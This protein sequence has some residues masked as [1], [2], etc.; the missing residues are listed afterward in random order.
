MCTVIIEEDVIR[1]RKEEHGIS[2]FLCHGNEL[3]QISMKIIYHDPPA[4][5]RDGALI[6]HIA[7]RVCQIEILV[8]I[9]LHHSK[10][11][12]FSRKKKAQMDLDRLND[13]GQ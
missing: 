13:Q 8:I 1:G 2:Y 5:R 9:L 3:L 4:L 11:D 7:N 6:I 10:P 12:R